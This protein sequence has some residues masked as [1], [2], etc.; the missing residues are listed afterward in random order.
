MVWRCGRPPT[1]ASSRARPHL[2]SCSGPCSRKEGET[3][4]P[5]SMVA[6]TL[7]V[8]AALFGLASAFVP[9]AP[10]L[11]NARNAAVT[12]TSDVLMIVS[13]YSCHPW[14][15]PPRRNR[16]GHF[17]TTHRLPTRLR[18]RAGASC[19]RGTGKPSCEPPRRHG[20]RLRPRPPPDAHLPS[21][22][23]LLTLPPMHLRV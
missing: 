18:S 7:L 4:P 22:P 6:R 12:R 20:K 1:D 16:R 14:C 5:R 8:V 15:M 13:R 2:G 3:Q 17:H 21:F 10:Q 11:S 23:S 19:A 9:A